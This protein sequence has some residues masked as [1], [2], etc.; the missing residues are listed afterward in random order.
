MPLAKI[1][2]PILAC[3]LLLI[4]E[5]QRARFDVRRH[6]RT[7]R[8]VTVGTYLDRS[9]QLGIATYLHPVAY[10]R[11]MFVESVVVA[12]DGAGTD[13]DGLTDLGI[14]YIG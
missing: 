9:H 12:G 14:A 10:H 4:V 1:L 8:N 3:S 2:D 7:G 6:G 13:I 11:T 5:G